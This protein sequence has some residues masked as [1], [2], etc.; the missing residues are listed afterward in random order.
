MDD[1]FTFLQLFVIFMI[2]SGVAITAVL[3]PHYPLGLDLFTKA[4]VFRGLMALFSGEMS[5]LKNQHQAC[6]VNAT[7][8]TESEYACLRLAHGLSFK[9]ETRTSSS[10]AKRLAFS[11]ALCRRQSGR[12]QSLWNHLATLQ[13][14]V[15]DRLVLAHSILLPR[16]TFPH[17]AADSYVWVRSPRLNRFARLDRPHLVRSSLTGARVQ[18]QSEQIWMYNRY[19]I[20]MEY[21]KRPRLP[22]PFVVISYIGK[23]SNGRRE[24]DHLIAS[25]SRQDMAI[26]SCSRQCVLKLK[27]YSDRKNSAIHRPDGRSS[28]AG[29]V[30]FRPE[31]LEGGGP[32]AETPLI[33]ATTDTASRTLEGSSDEVNGGHTWLE[34]LLNCKP[35]RQVTD[36]QQQMLVRLSL[37]SLCTVYT[38]E[39]LSGTG[40]AKLGRQ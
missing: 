36:N 32:N 3:Y 35:C 38:A 15:V 9:C 20:V 27:D 25:L 23:N 31:L 10:V 5:D 33:V 39:C 13:S 30:G 28:S 6:T 2:S 7:G 22:P 24:M 19:E 29:L 12:L 11:R 18:S 17:L 37:S 8:Q 26:S 14:N 1:F 16:Q 4:F 21:A 34:R 40:Q